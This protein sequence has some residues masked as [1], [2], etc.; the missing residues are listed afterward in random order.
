MLRKETH[1]HF[2]LN[3]KLILKFPKMSHSTFMIWKMKHNFF[4]ENWFSL[5]ERAGEREGERERGETMSYFLL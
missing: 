1:F 4:N 2:Q 3:M 5:K